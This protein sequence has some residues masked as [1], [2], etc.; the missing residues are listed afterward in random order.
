MQK[1]VQFPRRRAPVIVLG[2]NAFADPQ[3]FDTGGI[4]GLIE[5]NRDDQLRDA[6]PHGLGAGADAA[7]MHQRRGPVRQP[8]Q[9]NIFKVPH[10]AGQRMTADSKAAIFPVRI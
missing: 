10:Q 5:E 4:V 2:G 3:G 6:R 1:T 9:C 8:L 7:V